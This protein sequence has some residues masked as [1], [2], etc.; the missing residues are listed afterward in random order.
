MTRIHIICE[1][2][3]EVL[4]VKEVLKPHF[5]ERNIGLYPQL[6][7][8]AGHKGGNFRLER[9]LK[10]MR[11]SLYDRTAYC[12]TF[13]DF[14]GLHPKFPGKEEA[15]T[16]NGAQEKSRCLLDA[17]TKQLCEKLGAEPMRRFIPYVQM[18]EFEG[19]LFSDPEKFANGIG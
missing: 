16:K 7:G 13:F 5:T 10:N 18:Y 3:T 4:F 14:Y 2:K 9:L 8:E 19:L 12:T 17:L 1:G 6:I 11:P 15:L